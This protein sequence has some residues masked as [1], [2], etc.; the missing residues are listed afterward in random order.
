MT[1]LVMMVM[2]V[3]TYNGEEYED[4]DG[5]DVGYVGDDGLHDH[6]LSL[7]VAPSS[8]ELQSERSPESVI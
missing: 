8:K 2:R 7:W 5:E 3:V 1:M 6:D 4:G